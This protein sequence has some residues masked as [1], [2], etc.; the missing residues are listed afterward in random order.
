MK[1]LER[2][3]GKTVRCISSGDQFT[4]DTNDEF[5]SDSPYYDRVTVTTD[6]GEFKGIV[7]E[8]CTTAEVV[9]E[10]PNQWIIDYLEERVKEVDDL[11]TN[12]ILYN[13]IKAKAL[14]S[15]AIAGALLMLKAG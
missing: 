13:H 5:Y 3:R 1:A 15:G 2:L 12:D 11:P 10:N 8:N 9:D 6:D 7:Y 4:I 14:L